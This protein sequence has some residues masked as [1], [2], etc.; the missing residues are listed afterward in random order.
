MLTNRHSTMPVKHSRMPSWHAGSRT[1]DPAQ[2]NQAIPTYTIGNIPRSLTP[3][4]LTSTTPN[5]PGYT[6]TRLIGAIHGTASLT[7]RVPKSFLKSL[8]S[9]ITGSWGEA[10][11]LTQFLYQARDQAIE[12]MTKDAIEK[13]ANAVVGMQIRETEVMGCVVVNVSA[14]ACLVEKERAQLKRDSVQKSPFG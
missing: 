8:S 5:L 12:R 9:S 6:T 4:I 3:V 11:P 14:T 13:G 10:K 7:H 1:A 2:L